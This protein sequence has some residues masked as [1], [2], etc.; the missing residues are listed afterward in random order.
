MIVYSADIALW[1]RV[2]TIY[3]RFFGD[4]RPART[5]VP[6]RERH[7]GYPIEVAAIAATAER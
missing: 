2:N 1:D 5:I 7:D 6:T 4:D 3:A